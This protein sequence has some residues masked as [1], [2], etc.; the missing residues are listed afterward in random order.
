MPRST[1]A[2]LPAAATFSQVRLRGRLSGV[3][4]VDLPSGDEAVA[5]RIVVD[6]PAKQRGP[7]GRVRVDAIE[8]VAWTALARRRLL[9]WAEGD[10]IEVDGWLQRRF[11]KAGA[12][13]ASRTEVV[14]RE[15]R[16]AASESAGVTP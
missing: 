3:A 1:E 11:W 8:C 5:F 12:V 4:R 16:R 10:V 13:P 9:A 14:V 6:R 2:S 15:V 7:S